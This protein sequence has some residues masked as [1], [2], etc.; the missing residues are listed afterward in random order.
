ML[1]CR[2]RK[3]YQASKIEYDQKILILICQHPTKVVCLLGNVLHENKDHICASRKIKRYC[4]HLS[5]LPSKPSRGKTNVSQFGQTSVPQK[6]KTMFFKFIIAAENQ[7]RSFKVNDFHD[8]EKCVKRVRTLTQQT[9]ENG[10]IYLKR[11]EDT[12]LF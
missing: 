11:M 1:L 10:Q 3:I 6:K 4:Q 12:A 8:F 9:L 5:S 2:P 7:L